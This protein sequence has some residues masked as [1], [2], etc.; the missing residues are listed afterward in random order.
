VSDDRIV[1]GSL[2][3]PPCHCAIAQATPSTNTGAPSKK[4][5]CTEGTWK[6]C[7]VFCALGG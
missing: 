2:D 4:I 1:A 7:K 3:W 6:C 5:K